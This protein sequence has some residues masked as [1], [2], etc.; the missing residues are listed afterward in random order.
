MADATKK[1]LEKAYI[2]IQKDEY[3]QAVS[4]L[5]PI[6]NREP[7]NADA[8][9]LMANTVDDPREA[10]KAL[11]NVLKNDP[12]HVQARETLDVLNEQMP[13]TNEELEMLLEIEDFGFADDF[14]PTTPDEQL[15]IDTL[16]GDA[17]EIDLSSLDDDLEVIREPS[18]FD[19]I[20]AE[21]L[22]DLE[23]EEDPFADLLDE[24]APTRVAVEK[25]EPSRRSRI[26]TPVL[27][28]LVAAVLASVLF[29]ISG[30]NED[31]DNGEDVDSGRSD[32]P[33]LAVYEPDTTELESIVSNATN[34]ARQEF[35]AESEA[36]LVDTPEGGK[37]LF[38][39]ACVC[40]RPDCS[41]PSADEMPT[42]VVD[43]LKLAASRIPAA[44][45]ETVP[46]AGVNIV[47]CDTSD[48]VYR[49]YTPVQSV[50]D[51][52]RDESDENLAAFQTAWTVV[53]Q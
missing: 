9:W 17:T 25:E 3:D 26:L 11:I 28:V 21:D 12:S 39:E 27:V 1:Q 46:F 53:Q 49:A 33:V 35:G 38:I 19:D 6:L 7:N 34:D 23:A 47:V 29:V 30:T 50:R 43:S 8:W 48:A 37:A 18:D 24:P 13:P 4:I 44:M 40:I 22:D 14:V 16:F 42:I 52:R 36:S 41:G 31:E 15:E 5:K 2:H 20:V 10:R 32:L 51:F 45:E